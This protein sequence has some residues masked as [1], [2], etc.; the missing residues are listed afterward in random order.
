ML[1]EISTTFQIDGS[2]AL[3]AID[4][5]KALSKKRIQQISIIGDQHSGTTWLVSEISKCFNHTLKV[6]LIK[7]ALLFL[8]N[9]FSPL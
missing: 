6:R 2:W 7:I 1:L 4:K 9:S 8:Y 5:D 3:S